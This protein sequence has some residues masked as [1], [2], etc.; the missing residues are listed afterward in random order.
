MSK[1]IT[2]IKCPTPSNEEIDRVHAILVEEMVKLFDKHKA[3]YG[4]ADKKLIV[5]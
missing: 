5:T 2:V 4:W 3:A 1:P